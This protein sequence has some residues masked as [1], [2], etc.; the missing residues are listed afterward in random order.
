MVTKLAEP[1]RRHVGAPVVCIPLSTSH[2][3]LSEQRGVPWVGLG[4]LACGSAASWGESEGLS[5][6]LE[7]HLTP[8]SLLE[9]D[10]V[11]CSLNLL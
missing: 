11:S 4:A 9:E 2:L 3:T 6:R 5:Q 10:V 8:V 1:A 7:P